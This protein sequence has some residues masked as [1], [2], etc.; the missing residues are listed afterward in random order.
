MGVGQLARFV[1]RNSS[2][3]DV[4]RS[5]YS[6]SMIRR[7]LYVKTIFSD[8]RFYRLKYIKIN[9]QTLTNYGIVYLFTYK[10][11]ESLNNHLRKFV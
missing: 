10:V 6:N 9:E 5:K 11:L 8:I 1:P 2:L 3:L 7:L 4:S